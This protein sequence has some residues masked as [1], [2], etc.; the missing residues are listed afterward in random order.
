MSATRYW[1]FK[2]EPESYSISD[3][4][5]DGKT[6]WD[7]VRNYQA[8]NL[9]RDDMR[10]GDGVLFSHSNVHPPAIV[11][12]ARIIRAGVP[13]P[14]QFDPDHPKFDPK[15][16]PVH[17]RWYA[18]DIAFVEEFAAPISLESL[19]DI[20]ALAGMELLRRGSRLSVQ[21]VTPAQWTVILR[22]AQAS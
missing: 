12:T 15:A 3:L 6:L 18:V 20:P 7:G 4:R 13:D 16:T 1:L 21:P 14:T 19:R 22:L 17:P 10:V 9:L 8:R 2:S 11:G 5:R